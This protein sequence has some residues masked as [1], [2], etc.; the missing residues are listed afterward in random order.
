MFALFNT[1][2]SS[3]ELHRVISRHRLLKRA[4]KAQQKMARDVRRNNPGGNA[5]LPTTIKHADGTPLSEI[6]F[7]VL[8][9]RSEAAQVRRID[10]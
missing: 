3:P 7:E 1:M 4:V 8:M 6:E 2:D 5:Y 10:R 9:L